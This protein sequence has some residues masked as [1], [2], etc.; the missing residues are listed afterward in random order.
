M[1]KTAQLSELWLPENLC[2]RGGLGKPWS[3]NLDHGGTQS[4]QY[5]F[6]LCTTTLDL[7]E[8]V[9]VFVSSEISLCGAGLE[10]IPV[11]TELLSGLS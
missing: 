1:V 4:P 5:L 6:Q 7:T 11:D 10:R 8:W 2:I 9:P 3:L